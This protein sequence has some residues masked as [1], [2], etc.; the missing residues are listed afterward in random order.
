[1]SLSLACFTMGTASIALAGLVTNTV[2]NLGVD[3]PAVHDDDAQNAAWMKSR[4]GPT[5]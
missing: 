5:W 1:L 4:C 2:A 3:D